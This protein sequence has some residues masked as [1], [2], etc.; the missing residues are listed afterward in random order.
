M[1]R[2]G[3]WRTAL[4]LASAVCSCVLARC[5]K[6]A[7][8][9]QTFMGDSSLFTHAVPACLAHCGTPSRRLGAV[10]GWKVA[11]SRSKRV[12]KVGGRSWAG[13]VGC[14]QSWQLKEDVHTPRRVLSKPR[15]GDVQNQ[16]GGTDQ[17]ACS[18]GGAGCVQTWGRYRGCKAGRDAEGVADGRAVSPEA[19]SL[20]SGGRRLISQGGGE[21]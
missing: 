5:T 3:A 1:T 7:L 11:M 19:G 15:E 2:K 9:R 13:E 12:C 16:A 10:S 18:T 21:L 20:H 14:V 4:A 8:R 17:E 6:A